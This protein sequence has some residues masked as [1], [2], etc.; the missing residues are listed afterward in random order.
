ML[1]SRYQS[2]L[3]KAI[4]DLLPGCVI[5]KNDSDYLP[6]VP[7]LTIFHGRRW[8]MLEVKA[9]EDSE[10]QPNQD[11]YVQEFGKLSF[12]SFIF[13]QNEEEVLRELQNALE[14]RRASRFPKS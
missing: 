14:P 5:L 10:L 7:D 4:E 6:G 3:I 1:E 8:A 2:Y 12:V 9:S 13:P 11:Y